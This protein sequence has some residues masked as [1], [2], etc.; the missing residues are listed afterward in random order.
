MR[1]LCFQYISV[2]FCIY[3]VFAFFKKKKRQILAAYFVKVLSF[4][5]LCV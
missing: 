3:F 5:L 2:C 4:K 1:H